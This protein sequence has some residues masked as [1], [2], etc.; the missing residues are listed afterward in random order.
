[1]DE[2]EDELQCPGGLQ[3][4]QENLLRGAIKLDPENA[5]KVLLQMLYANYMPKISENI[6]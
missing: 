2:V 1:M 6:Q 4:I 5:R 3:K